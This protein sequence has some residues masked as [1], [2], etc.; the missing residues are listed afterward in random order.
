[1]ILKPKTLRGK[2]II[3]KHGRSWELIESRPK[4]P[5]LNNESGSLVQSVQTQDRRWIRTTND[6]DFEVT[7][8]A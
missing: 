8:E 5:V 7:W 3:K 6:E 2:N 4:V 1:M